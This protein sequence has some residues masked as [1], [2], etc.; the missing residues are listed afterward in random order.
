M[1]LAWV[2]NC[3]VTKGINVVIAIIFA[4]LII[5]IPVASTEGHPERECAVGCIGVSEAG[6]SFS[7]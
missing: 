5:T 7:F 1:F 2:D 6:V 3:S 4:M